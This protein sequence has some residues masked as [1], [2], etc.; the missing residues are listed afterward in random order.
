MVQVLED[1]VG[2]MDFNLKGIEMIYDLNCSQMVCAALCL[3]ALVCLVSHVYKS[4]KPK[5]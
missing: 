4:F 5:V 2:Q 3:I 1:G